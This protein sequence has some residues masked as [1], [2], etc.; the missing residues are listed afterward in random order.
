MTQTV[1]GGAVEQQDD[2][3]E[4]L[5]ETPGA[6][7]AAVPETELPEAADGALAPAAAAQGAPQPDASTPPPPLSDEE[8]RFNE[9]LH[10]S[11]AMLREQHG[12]ADVEAKLAAFQR[13][14]ARDPGLRV[15]LRQQ[16]HPWAWMYRQAERALALEEI[17]S[18]PDAYRSRVREEVRVELA[19]QATQAAAAG[20]RPPFA[21]SLAAGRS[22]APRAA[23]AWSGPSA[24]DDILRR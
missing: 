6:T 4:V 9:R 17:G 7:A 14:A 5:A 2:L 13:E 23:G 16:A 10:M 21:P 19:A 3:A 8:R 22:S 18:D 12:N 1:E 20:A 11:E 24:L 15:A